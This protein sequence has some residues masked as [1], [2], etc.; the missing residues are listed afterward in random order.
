M[1]QRHLPWLQLPIQII[2]GA[3]WQPAYRV[4]LLEGF[5]GR[6]LLAIRTTPLVLCGS[7]I[8]RLLGL[9]DD[10]KHRLLE[11]LP[12]EEESVLIPN[13]VRR[14]QIEV[15]ALHA[16]LEQA[17]DV[18]VVWVGLKRK[19]AAVIHELL[20][21]RG[22]VQA[23]ILDGDFLLLSLDVVVFFVFGA[24]WQALPRQRSAQE[25]KKHMSDSLEVIATRLLVANVR[26]D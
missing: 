15:V 7:G 4:Y 22:L 2:E 25:V 5:S 17:Q 16:A 12:L 24:S 26:V 10:A 13:E 1:T 9:V 23:K 11:G 14:S 8:C 19:P 6:S 21:L 18:P 3:R 20:E